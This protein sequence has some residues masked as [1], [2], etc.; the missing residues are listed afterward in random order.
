MVEGVRMERERFVMVW[1]ELVSKDLQF[2]DINVEL[3]LNRV[4]W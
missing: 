2:L 3:I 4:E 1:R